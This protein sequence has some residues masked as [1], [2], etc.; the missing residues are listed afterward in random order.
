MAQRIKEGVKCH[1]QK[2]RRELT[3][4]EGLPFRHLLAE[5]R[6]RVALERAGVEFRERIFDPLTT[7]FA[8]LSQAVASKDSTCEDAVCRVNAERVANGKP[9]CSADSSSYCQAR[10]R[11]PEQAIADLTRETGQAL[12]R[13]AQQDWLWKGRHVKIVDGS[14]AE[15][16]DTAEN[17]AEYPQSSGQKPGLGFPM[18]RLATLF[19]WRWGR[20]W[21]APSDRVAARRPGS[22]ACF[23]KF[24]MRSCPATFCW[25]IACTTPI[26]ISPS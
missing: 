10:G 15:M 9:A 25:G 20:C 17:Q 18:L 12:E 8:F 23:A 6:V 11:L 19:R 2:E 26:A 24:N 21:I 1:V 16:T 22:K 7:L 14:T 3:S 5:Q 4:S 13:D